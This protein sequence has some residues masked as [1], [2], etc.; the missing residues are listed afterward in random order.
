MNTSTSSANDGLEG[1]TPNNREST[2]VLSE[3]ATHVSGNN[4]TVNEDEPTIQ[5]ESQMLNVEY[6]QYKREEDIVDNRGEKDTEI[7]DKTSQV[8]D[9]GLHTVE[10]KACMSMESSRETSD[11]DGVSSSL[12][13]SV[14]SIIKVVDISNQSDPSNTS[15]DTSIMVR[16][17]V[18]NEQGPGLLTDDD[19]EEEEEVKRLFDKLLKERHQKSDQTQSSNSTSSSDSSD[20]F[21]DSSSSSSDSTINSNMGSPNKPVRNPETSAEMKQYVNC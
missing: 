3:N 17:A 6:Q 16:T 2:A 13:S 18:P 8:L 14:S 19:L 21:D 20:S 11:S 1:R 7:D 10:G 4:T 12:N 15:E 5:V 9:T